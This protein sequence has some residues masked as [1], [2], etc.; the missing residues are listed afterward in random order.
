MPRRACAST[1][2]GWSD[3]SPLCQDILTQHIMPALQ[4]FAYIEITP[5]QHQALWESYTEVE[6][7]FP[8][9]FAMQQIIEPTDIY[10]VFRELFAR[11]P[12]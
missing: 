12:A 10:P 3:D 1:A 2:S 7:A 9:T 6:A 11:Q 4:Y 8:D 5:R